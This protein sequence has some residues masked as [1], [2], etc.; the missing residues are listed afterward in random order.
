MTDHLSENPF[1]QLWVLLHQTRDVLHRVREKEVAKHGITATQSAV[2]FI[3]S[4]LDE[5]A[6]PTRISRWLLR[7]PHSISNILARMERQG[8]ITK[9]PN[10][11]NPGETLI[12]LTEKGVLS[13]EKTSDINLINEILCCLTE[14][15]KQGLSSSLKKLR[16]TAL[17]HLIELQYVPY[18]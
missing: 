18:P 3:I 4:A 10:P 13:Y 7:E 5:K 2:L 17:R 15:E 6:T 14:E 8:F 16:D 12:V 9:Q 11:E 1:Y